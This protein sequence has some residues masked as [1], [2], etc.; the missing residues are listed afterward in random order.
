[1]C[2]VGG[3]VSSSMLAGVL[4]VSL[5]GVSLGLSFSAFL[6]LGVPGSEGGPFGPG[7]VVGPSTPNITVDH[8]RPCGAYL[9]QLSM[10]KAVG[11]PSPPVR[12]GFRVGK[13]KGLLVATFVF[14]VGLLF[15]LV[16]VITAF[17]WLSHG[18]LLRFIIPDSAY[19]FDSGAT[20]ELARVH[21]PSCALSCSGSTG[22]GSPRL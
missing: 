8:P 10:L 4:G 1:M 13:N 14:W 22:R 3:L 21:G 16:W 11:G 7:L 15:V 18:I 6:P 19:F 9:A 5:K 12:V 20:V 2:E 17:W